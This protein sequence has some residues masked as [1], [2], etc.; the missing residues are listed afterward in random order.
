MINKVKINKTKC[1]Q[2]RDIHKQNGNFSEN[3][4]D[5]S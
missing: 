5:S 3:V 1:T 2:A 4:L